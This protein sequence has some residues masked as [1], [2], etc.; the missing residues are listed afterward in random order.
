[1]KIRRQRISKKTSEMMPRLPLIENPVKYNPT[2]RR[3]HRQTPNVDLISEYH[4]KSD[5]ED[6]SSIRW[7]VGKLH[8][9]PDLWSGIQKMVGG[10]GTAG[11]GWSS[12]IRRGFGGGM[13]RERVGVMLGLCKHVRY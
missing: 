3:P 4:S 6:D 11:L 7:R 8:P 10:F 2:V 13:V 12:A 1:M 5:A 9:S